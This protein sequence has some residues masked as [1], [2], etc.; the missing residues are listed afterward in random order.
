MKIKRLASSGL[1][2]LLIACSNNSSTSTH[3]DID[4]TTFDTWRQSPNVL[5]LDVR[6]PDEFA[7]GHVEGA[8]NVDYYASDFENQLKNLPKKD[9]VLVYCASG[10]RSSASVEALKK[11]GFTYIGNLTGGYNNYKNR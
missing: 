8:L 6:T 11:A 10:R 2:F 7:A 9:T 1:F 5:V 4:A 3:T